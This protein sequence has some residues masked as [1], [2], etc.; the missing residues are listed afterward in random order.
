VIQGHY[1]QAEEMLTRARLLGYDLT[2]PHIALVIE[3]PVQYARQGMHRPQWNR[4]VRDELLRA[5]PTSWVLDDTARVVALLPVA[6]HPTGQQEDEDYLV[7]RVERLHDTLQRGTLPVL[8]CSFGIGRV[9]KTIQNLPQSFR[10][11]Q[12]ALEIGRQLFGEGQVHA[13]AQ[14]G[15]YRLLFHLDGQQ[16]LSVFYQE[17]LGPLLQHDNQ[18]EGNS[19]IKTLEAFFRYN[20]N[21]SEVARTTNFHRN[22]LIY[23]L[24]RIEELLG[25]SLEDAETR[26]SLQI[27]LKIHNLQHRS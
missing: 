17:M 27:A 26:L 13:F 12:R 9:A 15:V 20:G 16:E 10:E 6:Q 22:S 14:L 11:A 4:R 7:A 25:R 5:W 23:R 8:D 1:Q 24:K 2:L 21:L 3:P 18:H 19:Y